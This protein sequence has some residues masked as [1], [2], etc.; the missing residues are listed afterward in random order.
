MSSTTTTPTTR[1]ARVPSQKPAAGSATPEKPTA[2]KTFV[3]IAEVW[4]PSDDGSLLELADGLF[5]DAPAFGAITRQMVFGRAEGLPGRA[6]D[7]GHPLLLNALDGSY[8]RRATAAKAAGLKC[9][10]AIPIF[11][12]ERLT[13]VLVLLC[14]DAT[15]H[16][17]SI[18]LWHRNPRVTTDLSLIDGYFGTQGEELEADSRDTFM[19]RGTGLPGLAWQREAAVIV[20]DVRASKHFL[21]GAAASAAGIQSALAVPIVARDD[22]NWVMALLASAQTPLALRVESWQPAEGG[23]LTRAFGHCEF[24]GAL[25]EGPTD[26][27]AADQLGAI[28]R[29]WTT[30]T[31]QVARGDEARASRPGD[32]TDALSSLLAWPVI[33][34]DGGVTEVL[35]LHY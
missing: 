4:V 6:W 2:V 32:D 21:R 27:L 12:H 29:A 16:V 28:G 18:E 1:T 17:G 14:G 26:G 35:A 33:G 10:I 11:A 20:P 22:H 7:E 13:S 31:A 5:D 19:P 24:L 3:R 34:T 25:G 15:A 30:A 9:A 23:R 8:F